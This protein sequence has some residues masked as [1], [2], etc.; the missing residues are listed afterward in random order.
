MSV[1]LSK[2]TITQE[3]VEEPIVSFET[4]WLHPFKGMFPNL[5]DAVRACDEVDMSP[6]QLLRP[7]TV[8]KGTNL[9]EPILK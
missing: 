2:S 5:D 1:N 8:A 4:W 9:W 7:I 6:E 3:G